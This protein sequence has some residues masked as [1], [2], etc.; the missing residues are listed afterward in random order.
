M[1]AR[2][3]LVLVPRRPSRRWHLADQ[4]VV[5]TQGHSELPRRPR[6]VTPRA[7]VPPNYRAVILGPS[8][9]Q[10]HRSTTRHPGLRR[11]KARRGCESPLSYTFPPC[12]PDPDRLAVPIRPV[13]VRAAC[14]P[15]PHLRGQAALSFTGLLRQPGGGAL[16]S[17]LGFH[18]ASW[19]TRPLM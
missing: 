13:V 9:P 2:A 12:L 17:P 11:V 7:V 8:P 14:H 1:A 6:S 15:P 5:P 4:T 18:G 19:R 16:S 10:N 3:G